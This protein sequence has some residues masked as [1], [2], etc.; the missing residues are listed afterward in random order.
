MEL[1][2][3]DPVEQRDQHVTAA[4]ENH[5]D[6]QKNPGKLQEASHQAC[7]LLYHARATDQQPAATRMANAPTL[8]NAAATKATSA[9]DHA[10]TSLTFDFVIPIASHHDQGNNHR[11]GTFERRL[12]LGQFVE[13]EVQ[14][15]KQRDEAEGGSDEADRRGYPAGDAP[16]VV[17]DKGAGIE[18]KRSEN[19]AERQAMHELFQRYPFLLVDAVPLDQCNDGHAAAE[20]G[21][22]DDEENPEYLPE[23]DPRLAVHE[24]FITGNVADRA[25]ERGG[26][27]LELFQPAVQVRLFPN[28]SW[29]DGLF[30]LCSLSPQ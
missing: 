16:Q 24:G 25:R 15:G 12:K 10:L 30:I 19:L 28:T 2:D 20:A 26:F 27:A 13:L 1:I 21:G 4:E 29:D 14:P 17:T 23:G 11:V 18:G 9:I 22:A 7:S 5:A 8:R 3:H 6:L